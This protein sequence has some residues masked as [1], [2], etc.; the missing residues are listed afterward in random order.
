MDRLNKRE[1]LQISQTERIQML[2]QYADNHHYDRHSTQ[3]QD[4]EGLGPGITNYFV[5]QRYLIRVLALISFL[6]LPVI[7]VYVSFDGL[8]GIEGL[9]LIPRMSFGNMGFPE[10]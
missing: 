1:E 4:I 3:D 8:N 2:Q 5:M 10:A 7:C 9:S 6:C